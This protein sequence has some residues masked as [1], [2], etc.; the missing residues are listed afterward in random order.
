VKASVTWEERRRAAGPPNCVAE[1]GR[2]EARR[3]HERRKAPQD[4]TGRLPRLTRD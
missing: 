1:N 2:A 3:L 4:S